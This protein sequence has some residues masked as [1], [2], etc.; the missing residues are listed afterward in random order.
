MLEA[1]EGL[2]TA[3]ET[4]QTLQSANPEYAENVLGDAIQPIIAAD[5]L[6]ILGIMLD[7]VKL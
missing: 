5:A 6:S 4:I 1:L 3:V 7:R 2:G